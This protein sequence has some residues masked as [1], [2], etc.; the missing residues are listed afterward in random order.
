MFQISKCPE[1]V[2]GAGARKKIVQVCGGFGQDIL[3][4]TGKSSFS[5]SNIGI[6]ILD[7]LTNNGF[8]LEHSTIIDEPSAEVVDDIVTGLG[9]KT[10]NCVVAIGG[11]SV[12]DAGKAVS[13]MLPVGGSVESY[14]EGIGTKVHPGSKIPFIAMPTT[15]GTGSEATKNAVISKIGT[16]GYKK[17]L[18][19]TN[20]IP[21]IALIDPELT[22]NCP[23]E[24]TA[25][26]GMDAFT[27]LVESFLSTQSNFF[28]DALAID[29]IKK[30][31]R[32]IERAVGSGND[33]SARSDMSYAAYLSG[34]T[35][36]NAGLGVVHG[37]AQP[38]GSLFKIPHGVVCGTLMAIANR[39]TLEKIGNISEYGTYLSKYKELGSL[40]ADD[41]S[42]SDLEWQFVEYLEALSVK[43]NIPGLADYGVSENS[44]GDIIARTGIKNH[45]VQLEDND[46]SRI[47]K[48]RLYA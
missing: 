7:N 11:G 17:S 9:E 33:I 36:A 14:L 1:L 48:S 46:L 25:A 27:Q 2:F 10:I 34:I 30:I 12:V 15:S 39:V 41:G 3:L 44:F 32:S 28:T 5:K 37:F 38:L 6:E 4:L 13:A 20:F 29:G 22:I 18:R 43:L 21:D 45:P 24:I 35:L 40:I 23:P 42:K 19:H 47:L 26:T 8:R 16:N 31:L